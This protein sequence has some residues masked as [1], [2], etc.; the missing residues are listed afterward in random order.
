M[1]ISIEL[2]IF[3][4]NILSTS[5]WKRQVFRGEVELFSLEQIV[6]VPFKLLDLLSQNTETTKDEIIFFPHRMN[7]IYSE[8]L[9]I[10]SIN[11]L[12]CAT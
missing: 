4:A 10:C 1:R 8:L 12:S 2:V 7:H 5:D 3:T 11:L 9:G 6:K